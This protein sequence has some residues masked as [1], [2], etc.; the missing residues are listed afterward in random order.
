MKNSGKFTVII[1]SVIFAF[2]GLGFFSSGILTYKLSSDFYK[3]AIKT[4]ATIEDIDVSYSYDSDGDRKSDYDV[5]V[6]FVV[7]GKEYT[8][9]LNSYNSSMRVG[10]KTTVYYDP[11]SPS[12]FRS[13]SGTT[14]GLIFIIIGAII[15]IAGISVIIV[16]IIKNSKNKKKKKNLIEN[17][18]R[19]SAHID[20]INCNYNYSVNGKHPYKIECSYS[21]P[22]TNKVYLFYSDN[23]WF[24]VEAIM[25]ASG[26]STVSV[27]IDKNDPTNYYIDVDELRKNIVN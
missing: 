23:I 8:G 2:V 26:I 15:L 1:V 18:K 12:N 17:G 7:D 13:G 4:E 5:V 22:Y 25:N 20:Q 19:V 14:V 6:S 24:N 21:D 27:Y 9:L 11:K 16:N 3:D 10:G